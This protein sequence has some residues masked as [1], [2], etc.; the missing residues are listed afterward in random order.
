MH[1]NYIWRWM[2]INRQTSTWFSLAWKRLFQMGSSLLTQSWNWSRRAG[3]T[4]CCLETVMK[5]AFVRG[6]LNDIS[7]ELQQAPP[8]ETLIMW[9]LLTWVRVL[10]KDM[11]EDTV[12][13][14]QFPQSKSQVLFKAKPWTA[15][16]CY[17]CRSQGHMAW[18][19]ATR[20]LNGTSS[21]RLCQEMWCFNCNEINHLRNVRETAQ[22]KRH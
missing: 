5:L 11:A 10:T 8:I 15:I 16:T 22:R 18:D 17:R 14:M 21:W 3:F 6:F 9:D 7:K 1:S 2:R 19:W 20:W 12:A 4:G 13:T